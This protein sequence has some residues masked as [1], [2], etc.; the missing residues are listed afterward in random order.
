MRN[1]F[2]NPSHDCSKPENRD[3]NTQ[4]FSNVTYPLSKLIADIELGEIGLPDIQR[5]FLL[6]SGLTTSKSPIGH[7]LT[8]TQNMPN[9]SIQEFWTRC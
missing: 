9:G 2:Q 6:S 8:I 7:Q 1:F 4:L 5:P 3:M